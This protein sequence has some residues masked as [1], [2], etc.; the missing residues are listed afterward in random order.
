MAR[1]ADRARALLAFSKSFKKVR[2]ARTAAPRRRRRRRAKFK[3][4]RSCPELRDVGKTPV[5]QRSVSL[6]QGDAEKAAA[7]AAANQQP[8]PRAKVLLVDVYRQRRFLS[9][10]LDGNG[11]AAANA[12]YKSIDAAPNMNVARTK[13]SI[14]LVSELTMATKRAQAGLANAAKTTFGDE[15]LKQHVYRKCLQ[16]LIY[17]ISCTTPH[18]FQ[19]TNFQTPTWCYECEGLLWGLA[20][21]GEIRTLSWEPKVL[22]IDGMLQDCD[23]PN[24]G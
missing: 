23:V 2:R 21:Q 15:E 3:R 4:S 5:R 1:D 11:S 22:T 19:T 10:V 12:F 17:P 20:R 16:A 9:T 8:P 18:N 14:P 7:T 24:A 6:Q 13:T